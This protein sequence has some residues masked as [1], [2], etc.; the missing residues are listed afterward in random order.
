MTRCLAGRLGSVALVLG[1]GAVSACNPPAIK[2]TQT[3][4][5]ADSAD[6]VMI[7]MTTDMLDEGVRTGHVTADTAFVYQAAQRMDLRGLK[8]TFYEDGKQSSV[9]TANRG[10][11]Q[12]TTG[13]LD[14]RG[15]VR[16]VT[17]DGRKLTTPHLVYDKGAGTLRSD[18]SFVYD[19]REEHLTGNRFNSD[20]DFR[21]VII[22]Q[23]KAIQRGAGMVIPK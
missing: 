11:Y 5:R 17:T 7:A 10:D 16:V 20:L 8:V 21:N 15:N 1:I 4:P 2:L 23:P 6:Q 12:M 9:L 3:A 22:D 19:S 14:A 13:S 18:T